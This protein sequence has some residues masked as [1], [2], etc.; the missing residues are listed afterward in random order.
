MIRKNKT[1]SK[2]NGFDSLERVSD[3]F[4]VFRNGKKLRFNIIDLPKWG[5]TA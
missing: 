4:F 2:K 5:N 1:I 3:L